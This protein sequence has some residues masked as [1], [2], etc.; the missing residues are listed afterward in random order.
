MQVLTRPA[1]DGHGR[2][3][4]GD[5]GDVSDVRPRGASESSGCVVGE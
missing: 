1:R 5:R 2:V 3:K 4:V